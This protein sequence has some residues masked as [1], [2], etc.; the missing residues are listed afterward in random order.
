MVAP[1]LL[2]CNGQSNLWYEHA[3]VVHNGFDGRDRSRATGSGRVQL[4]WAGRETSVSTCIS[5]MSA[6]RARKRTLHPDG[7]RLRPPGTSAASLVTRVPVKRTQGVAR[8]WID[9]FLWRRRAEP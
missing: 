1:E 3:V 7:N 2:Q 5:S 8:A 4:G 9:G 6:R